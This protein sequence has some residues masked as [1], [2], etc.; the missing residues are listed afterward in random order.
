M[1]FKS[2]Y[3]EYRFNKNKEYVLLIVTVSTLLITIFNTLLKEPST[4]YFKILK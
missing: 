2:K 4:I 3:K 1:E